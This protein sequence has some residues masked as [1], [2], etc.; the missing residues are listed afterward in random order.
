MNIESLRSYYHYNHSDDYIFQGHTH[1]EWELNIILRG[2]MEI[3]S[4]G[5]IF[6]LSA[7]NAILIK[8][9]K[10][11]QNR[12]T[13]KHMAE[14]LVAQFKSSECKSGIYKL[15]PDA[16]SLVA[17]F[18]KESERDGISENSAERLSDDSKKLLELLLSELNRCDKSP[19]E[20]DIAHAQVYHLAVDFMKKNIRT[21][22]SCEQ[23]ARSVG[24]CKTTLKKVFLRYTGMGCMR[25]FGEMK[26]HR[27]RTMLLDGESCA[28][29]SEALGFSSQAYFSKKYKEFFG[30]LPSRSK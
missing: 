27:A 4:E 16:E 13:G 17:L 28:T 3:T 11:H 6:S 29:V 7:G 8:P 9:S 12:V 5:D 10:F 15:S 20:L 24:V 2:S 21:N 1:D 19:K 23:V 22:L 25:F 14:M 30:V 26:L 18:I